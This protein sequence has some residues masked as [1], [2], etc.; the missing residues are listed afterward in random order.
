MEDKKQKILVI[1]GPTASGKTS[2]SISIAKK[3][4]GEI[5]SADS[6]Q[7][8]RGLNI[9]T[10]KITEKEMDGVPH[11]LI[12]IVEPTEV[13]TVEQFKVMAERCIDDITL[14]NRLPMIVG[15]TGFYIDSIVKNLAIPKVPPNDEL[16]EKLNK[17]SAEELY[18]EL[19]EKDEE[20]AELIDEHNKRRLIRALE[21]IEAIGKV[22]KLNNSSEKY[23]VLSIGIQT[24]NSILKEKISSRLNDSLI[25]GLVEEV[26]SLLESG[27][28]KEQMNEFGLEYKIA[29]QFIHSDITKN[30]MIE[31]MKTELWQYAKRQRTW[32][33]RDKNIKWFSLEERDEIE[34]EVSK[35]LED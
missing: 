33:K 24:D 18:E 7:V 16:R 6:R 35:F 8:Y 21:I 22:P 31:K 5:I 28:G 13:F 12:D 29:S 15:G 1:L 26:K 27:I 25:E 3:F 20:R 9:G 30:E 11:Y 10:E 23:N 32:F 34:E 19:K 2:L 17:K 4:V 14:R